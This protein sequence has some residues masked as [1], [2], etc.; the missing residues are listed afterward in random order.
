[1]LI[2][3]VD[4]LNFESV[5][6]N[7]RRKYILGYTFILAYFHLFIAI[8]N[9][10]MVCVRCER[11]GTSLKMK[12]MSTICI[13][14]DVL[15]CFFLLVSQSID[16]SIEQF[17]YT[18]RTLYRQFIFS[19][20]FDFSVPINGETH[21][22]QHNNNNKL[23]TPILVNFVHYIERHNPLA[24]WKSIV[25]KI[26]YSLTARKMIVFVCSLI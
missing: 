15:T 19:W 14:L 9:R 7:D 8:I 4:S 2:H 18:H 16:R 17:K 6:R 21:T 25:L 1:M 20:Q 23:L 22:H 11:A 12:F 24:N 10:W 26:V 3:A 5:Y 13:V